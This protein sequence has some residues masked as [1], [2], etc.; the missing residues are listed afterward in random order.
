MSTNLGR[1]SRPVA[2]RQPTAQQTRFVAEYLKCLDA[3][4]AAR[5]ADY[6]PKHAASIGCNL[7]KLPHVAAAIRKAMDARAKRT[8]IAQDRVLKELA[9]VAFSDV[10]AT[11]DE[12]G[13][14]R[15]PTELDDDT[16][17][18][19]AS[20]EVVERRAVDAQGRSSIDYVHKIKLTEKPAALALLCRHLGLL[21][22]KLDLTGRTLSAYETAPDA[23]LIRRLEELLLKAKVESAIDVSGT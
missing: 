6:S 15:N 23:V 16:A 20:V 5:A 4:Q 7:L 14:P 19:V 3:T 11:F 18:A 2:P 9:R 17:A 10:R 12:A 1:R 13:H 22:D 8:E 21:N